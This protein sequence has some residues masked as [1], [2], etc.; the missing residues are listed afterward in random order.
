MSCDTLNLQSI[1][2][3]VAIG[4]LPEG[5]CP[6]SMQELA[7]AFADRLIVTPGETFNGFAIGSIEPASNVGPWFKNCEEFYVY[8]D[9]T[10]SYVPISRFATNNFTTVQVVD[11][12]VAFVVPDSIFKLKVQAWGAGGGGYGTNGG[13]GGGGGYGLKFFDVTPGQNINVIVGLGGAGGTPGANG[14]STTFSTLVAGGG[15]GATSA[16]GAGAAGG[17]TAGA[18]LSVSGGYGHEGYTSDGGRG[19]NSPNG[20]QGGVANDAVAAAGNGVAPGGGGTG[21]G[22]GINAAGNGANGRVVIEY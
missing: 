6:E 19:G 16:A 9:E 20:G 4:N 7:Q 3:S 15:V 13:G 8:D 10:A 17:T 14:G 12:S 22:A 1:S 21:A 18:D 11:A 2:L 5:F